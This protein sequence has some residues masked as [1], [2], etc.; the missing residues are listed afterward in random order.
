VTLSLGS[1]CSSAPNRS[2]KNRPDFEL[3]PGGRAD[4]QP[5]LFA[6]PRLLEPDGG[7]WRPPPEACPGCG[8]DFDRDGLIDL[9]CDCH[10]RTDAPFR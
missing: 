1:R 7:L 9:C 3:L 10:A 6:A 4:L 5:V 8:S 2:R